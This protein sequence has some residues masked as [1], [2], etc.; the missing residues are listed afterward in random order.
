VSSAL[1]K[2]EYETLQISTDF[3]KFSECQV[4]LRKFS[5]LIQDF[6][7]PVQVFKL[8]I[9]WRDSLV[10]FDSYQAEKVRNTRIVNRILTTIS[11]RFRWRVLLMCVWDIYSRGKWRSGLPARLRTRLKG[12]PSSFCAA[13]DVILSASHVAATALLHKRVVTLSSRCALKQGCQTRFSSGATSGIFNLKRAWPM[14]SLHNTLVISNDNF[15]L[16][17]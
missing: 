1:S 15:Q 2:F 3:I 14:K 11:V 13:R 10:A 4:P 12:A 5:P 8:H 6:L 16:F 9:F 17:L 7:T